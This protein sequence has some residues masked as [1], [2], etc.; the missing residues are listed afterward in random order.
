[1]DP[2]GLSDATQTFNDAHRDRIASLPVQVLKPND[3]AVADLELG[4]PVFTLYDFVETL[5]IA[6]V[7]GYHHLQSRWRLAIQRD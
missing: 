4:C 6:E 7:G 2:S 1:M 3:H 5:S